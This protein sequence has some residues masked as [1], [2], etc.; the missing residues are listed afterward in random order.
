METDA[1]HVPVQG[2]LIPVKC[3]E[4]RDVRIIGAVLRGRRF[5]TLAGVPG[6]K[7]LPFSIVECE[8]VR[9]NSSDIWKNFPREITFIQL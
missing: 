5:E 3:E 1:T 2:G 9:L 8:G 6:M 4:Q 7:S